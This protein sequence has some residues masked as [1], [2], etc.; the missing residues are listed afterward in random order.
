MDT[1]LS[2]A[3]AEQQEDADQVVTVSISF[4]EQRARRLRCDACGDAAQVMYVR[5]ESGDVL[6]VRCGEHAL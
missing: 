4:D 5:Q 2:L 6:A 1:S 3:I